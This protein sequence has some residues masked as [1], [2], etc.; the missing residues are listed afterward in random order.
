[1]QVTHDG[2]SYHPL[3][4]LSYQRRQFRGPLH[5]LKWTSS[6]GTRRTPTSPKMVHRKPDKPTL[7]LLSRLH[8]C[9]CV[10]VCQRESALL[11]RPYLSNTPPP[12]HT[13]TQAC[14]HG[15]GNGPTW[16]GIASGPTVDNNRYGVPA[17]QGAH[18]NT[19]IRA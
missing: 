13:P 12:A 1:M 3:K 18:K 14:A 11:P 4:K 7:S 9:V 19:S 8:V 6:P 17:S 16:Y 5:T 2:H 10:C 15:T